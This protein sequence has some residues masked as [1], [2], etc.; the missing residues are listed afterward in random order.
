M[1]NY[2]TLDGKKYKCPAKQW[3]PI[4]TKPGTVRYTLLGEVDVTFGSTA[5]KEWQGQ[6]EGPITPTDN[7]WGSITD[8]RTTLAKTTELAMIDHYGTAIT[9]VAVGP[10][11]EDSFMAAWD[12]PSNHFNITAR[13]IKVR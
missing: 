6:I 8:L 10:F 9:V 2:I 4:T 3:M 7:T 11:K 12:S 13:I 1:N 5:I